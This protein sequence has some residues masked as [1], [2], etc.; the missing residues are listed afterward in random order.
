MDCSVHTSMKTY[1]Y[2]LFSTLAAL[3][4]CFI[5][6]PQIFNLGLI[7]SSTYPIKLSSFYTYL[8]I[9]LFTYATEDS[10]AMAL[11][12]VK[13]AIVVGFL[14]LALV[15]VLVTYMHFF[16]KVF[17]WSDYT[18]ASIVIICLILQCIF[19]HRDQK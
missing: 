9:G 3:I 5:K 10:M 16:G 1:Y 11:G 15:I 17:L 13:S 19:A 2:G 18:G 4:I 14:N 12:A 6:S 7:D 8:I